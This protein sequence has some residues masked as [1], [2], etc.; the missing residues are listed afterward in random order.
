M[1]Q[2]LST[3]AVGAWLP[4]R[5]LPSGQVPRPPQRI[6]PAPAFVPSLSSSSILPVQRTT[7]SNPPLPSPY[8][9]SVFSHPK[10]PIPTRHTLQRAPVPAHRWCRERLLSFFVFSLRRI[11]PQPS[12]LIHHVPG[13]TRRQKKRPSLSARPLWKFKQNG[14]NPRFFRQKPWPSA[15]RGPWPPVRRNRP[16]PGQPGQP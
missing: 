1:P 16:R 8:V 2:F 3:Q 11:H 5:A 6:P 15:R 10:N 14:E 12:F 4:E 13:T 7:A 9:P